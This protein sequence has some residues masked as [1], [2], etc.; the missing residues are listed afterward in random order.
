ITLPSSSIRNLKNPGSVIDIYDT[1]IEHYHDLRGTDVKTSRKMWVVTDK[2]PSYGAMH[3]G[4][5]IVTHLD[6]ADPEGEKFLLNENALKL[7]TSKYWGIF[8]EI[9][10]NMQQSEWTFEGTLEVTSNVFNLYGMKKIGNLDCWTVPWLN[11]QIWKGVGY[12]NNGSDFEIWKND[13]GVALHTYAQL[14]DTFGWA[15]YKQVFRRYQNMSRKEKP[16]NNQEEIDKW[17]IIFSEEC[18]FNLA[19]LAAFWGI[20]LSQDAINKLEDLP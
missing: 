20:P 16:N 11:K 4:Y 18:K 13:A 19:P 2:Q 10:H 14:A 5:P 15:I 8:H 7:N 3:A 12:L 9:G 17:F 1:L 6:V